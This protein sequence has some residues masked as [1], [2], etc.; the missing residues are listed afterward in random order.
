[1]RT[2]VW[3]ALPMLLIPAGPSWADV[4][5]ADPAKAEKIVK[6]ALEK[7]KADTNLATLIKDESLDRA[8]PGQTFFAVIF[9]QFLVAL[10][11]PAPLKSSNAYPVD[12]DGHPV[13]ISNIHSLKAFFNNG[14]FPTKK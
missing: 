8:F 2:A 6:D 10:L 3:M 7:L 1:M 9:R 4:T 12:A 14:H 11:A 13:R 5:K